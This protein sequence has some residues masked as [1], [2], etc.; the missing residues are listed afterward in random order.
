MF[1]AVSK[2]GCNKKCG[3]EMNIPKQK[4]INGEKWKIDELLSTGKYSSEWFYRGFT[5]IFMKHIC[6]EL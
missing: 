3:N 1:N 6:E 4:D 5:I 2:T